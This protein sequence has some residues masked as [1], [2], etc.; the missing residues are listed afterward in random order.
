MSPSYIY[1]LNKDK[2]RENRE[3]ID[4][5]EERGREE[6]VGD[7]FDLRYISVDLN[8]FSEK[9]CGN[10]NFHSIISPPSN[11]KL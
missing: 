2:R 4:R 8:R 11:I 5:D 3:I 10:I 9:Y 6:R 1:E 7:V